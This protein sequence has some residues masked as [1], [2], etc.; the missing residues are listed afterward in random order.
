M[1][2]YMTMISGKR[3][4]TG[5]YSGKHSTEG[6]IFENNVNC[7][8]KRISQVNNR[9]EGDTLFAL[10]FYVH[11]NHYL[12]GQTLIDYILKFIRR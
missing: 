9:A 10:F 11:N 5:Q 12:V 3:T 4:V 6:A 7:M 1:P 2:M 8:K